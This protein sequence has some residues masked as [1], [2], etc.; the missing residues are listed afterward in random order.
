MPARNDRLGYLLVTF[1]A[2]LFVI[3]AGVSRVIL[4]SGVD[5]TE[6]TS[7]R[8]TGTAICLALVGLAIRPAA[9]QLPRGR[10]L[11][12]VVALG[13][14]GVAMLQWTYFVAIDRLSLGMALLLEY[15]APVLVALYA[16]FVQREQVRTRLWFALALSV[17]GLAVVAQSWQGFT[18]DP[19]GVV[20][21]FGAALSF[22]AYFLL[23]EH[24]VSRQDPLT[25]IFWAF[26]TAAVALNLVSPVTGLGWAEAS[27]TTS[28]LG[29][30]DAWSAPI[31]MLLGWVVVLGTLVPFGVELL[32]LQHLRATTVTTVAMLEP[33]GASILGWVWFGESLSLV[34]SLG[35]LA[36]VTGIFLAASARRTHPTLEQP[37]A[38]T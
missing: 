16:R 3:N 9:L 2:S 21:G 1:G 19:V 31:W 23:G 8:V 37:A 28:L 4:R 33:V 11:L 25:V 26:V 35:G 18:L 29:A 32:A 7:L 12:L 6:L 15:T 17:L 10:Q 24:G 14:T 13:F 22:S 20:A 34:Q 30:L 27:T 5:A 38:I 36:V